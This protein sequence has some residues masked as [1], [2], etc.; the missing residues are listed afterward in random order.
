MHIRI[1]QSNRENGHDERTDYL[2]RSPRETVIKPGRNNAKRG[3]PIC[4][5]CF[6]FSDVQRRQRTDS[7]HNKHAQLLRSLS[8]F[9]RGDGKDIPRVLTAE[10]WGSVSPNRPETRIQYAEELANTFQSEM[11]VSDKIP[12]SH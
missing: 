10:R 3:P 6:L 12:E 8:C 5:I 7:F 1:M 11:K 2:P 9:F 4:R